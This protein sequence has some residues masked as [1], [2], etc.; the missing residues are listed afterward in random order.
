MKLGFREDKRA[1][2]ALVGAILLL[3]ILIIALS[4]Y[5]AIIVPQQNAQTEFDHNQQVEDEMVDFRNALLEAR[6]D[7]RE[8]ATSVTLGTRYQSRTIAVNPP[9]AFGTLQTTEERNITVNYNGNEE[10]ELKGNQ[11]FEYTPSYS[12][13][14][15]AGTIR[16]E[17]TLV[18]HEF[19]SANIELTGQRLVDGNTVRLVPSEPSFDEN[20][21]N[22]VS[23]EPKPSQFRVLRPDDAEIT[24]PT[25]L[26]LDEWSDLLEDE[27]DWEVT[28]ETDGEIT[29]TYIG[30]EQPR[31]VYTPVEDQ[32]GLPPDDRDERDD[33]SES[34]TIINPAGPDSV[35]LI[36]TELRSPENN[37]TTLTFR[38]NA[39][40]DASIEGGRLPFYIRSP[41]E[42]QIPDRITSIEADETNVI[43]NDWVVRSDF[44]DLSDPIIIPAD[45]EKEIII[46]FNEDITRGQ[47]IFAIELRFETQERSTYFIG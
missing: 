2:S 17:N 22:R 3:A 46:R 18:Y 42:G 14:R 20:G 8:R 26:E 47:D 23:Y 21:V 31:I 9:P 37:K 27:N 32:E 30:E 39:D 15:D 28:N 24:L 13:Y 1:V 44:Q 35:A 4:S 7:N 5:Q 25:N 33:D 40:E 45:S 19:D 6:L 43:G 36:E 11:F 38:N 29:L 16:Y 10:F 34:P 41:G 12:E